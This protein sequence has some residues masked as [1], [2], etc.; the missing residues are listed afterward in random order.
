MSENY[1]TTDLALSYE[2]VPRVDSSFVVTDESYVDL[3]LPRENSDERSRLRIFDI[4]E[5]WI[6]AVDLSEFYRVPEP[7]DERFFNAPHAAYDTFELGEEFFIGRHYN[8]DNLP[9]LNK[10]VIS[11]KHVGLTLKL[12]EC[13]L[14]LAVRDTFFSHNGTEIVPN[15][16]LAVLDGEVMLAPV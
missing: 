14:I 15:D 11:R 8:P 16:T 9:I 1:P 13:G 4:N 2:R 6:R 3:L 12:G 10:N 5:R 7:D